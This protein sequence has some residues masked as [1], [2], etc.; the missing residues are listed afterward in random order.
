MCKLRNAIYGLKQ[1]PQA[2]YN[3]L[4]TFLLHSRFTNSLADALLFIYNK[5]YIHLCMLVYVDNIII[6]R[7]SPIHITRFINSLSIRFSLKDLGDLTYFIS[8]KVTHTASGLHLTQ[9][10]Y[11]VD[12]LHNTKMMN[13]KTMS[14]PLFPTSELT[15]LSGQPLDYARGYQSFVGSLQYIFLTRPDISFS[16][17]KL[18]QYMHRPTTAIGQP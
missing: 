1:V 4:R 18:C 2:W 14:T 17:K 10:R 11:I 9:H 6:T 3:D 12:L 15:L 8:V 13:A 5:E 7:N 16:V